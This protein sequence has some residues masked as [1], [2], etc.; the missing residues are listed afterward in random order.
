M[1]QGDVAL[2]LIEKWEL[3]E[4]STVAFHNLFTY[5]P[6]LDKL[7]ELGI[8]GCGTLWQN[9]FQGAQVANKGTLAKESWESDFAIDSKKLAVF[10]LDNKIATCST[11]YIM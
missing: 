6:L 8:F 1:V 4:G 11:N 9:C 7:A 10:W 2:G 5:L 3:K